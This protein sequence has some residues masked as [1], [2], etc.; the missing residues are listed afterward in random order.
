V[1]DLL[2]GKPALAITNFYRLRSA[3]LLVGDSAQHAQLRCQLY[4][5][6]LKKHLF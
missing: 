1:R 3:G 6:F 5:K 2:Q 4:A